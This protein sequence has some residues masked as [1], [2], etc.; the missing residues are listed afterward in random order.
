[1]Y[2]SERVSRFVTENFIPV[3]VHVR[4]QADEFRRLGDRYGVQWTPGI[5]VLDPDGAERHRVEGFLPAEDLIAQLT[6]GLG[7]AAFQRGDWADAEQRFRTVTERHP[8]TEAAP[9]AMYWAGVARHKAGNA[10]DALAE[11][12]RAIAERYPDSAWAR[13]ASV[14]AR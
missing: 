8:E 9:E 5:L 13:K 7:R 10:P 12:A 3:R 4:D 11:T 1:V 6:L 2:P 14:W